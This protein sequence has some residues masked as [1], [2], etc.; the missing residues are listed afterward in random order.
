MKIVVLDGYPLNSG[1]LDWA[2]LREL[3]ELCVHDRTVPDQIE[4]RARNAGAILSVR[5]PLNRE[6][7][8]HLT[9]LRYIG[10]LGSDPAPI[11]QEAARKRGITV[12]HAP[13]IDAA[14]IAQH[15]MAL[16]LELTNACGHHAHAVRNGRWSKSPDFTF[17]FQ[18]ITL[19]AGKVFGLV[20]Y[21]VVARSVAAMAAAFEMRI[22]AFDPA[23]KEPIPAEI[24]A[25]SL[26]HLFAESDVISLHCAL[27][28]LT[29][30]MINAAN[31]S[32]MKP[33]AWLLNT[34]H[35]A[36]ID[37]AALAEALQPRRLAGAGLD[38][39]A[40]EPPSQRNP[41]LRAPHC[42][43]TPRL[44]WASVETRRAILE[45]AA[46][47]LREFIRSSAG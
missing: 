27:T 8:R 15:T 9:A 16:L 12:Q 34:A 30:R 31:L 17:R 32:R 35:G 7:I 25:H 18:P 24:D 11:N 43:I 39:L 33:G 2:P 26:D 47:Q 40:S 46:R 20:G 3:G 19:L 45:T 1:D 38:A 22:L 10:I 13:G 14:S 44:G 41:L 42:L 4:P 21:G 29:E 37:E 6:T 23:Q 36:L 5:T 28:P